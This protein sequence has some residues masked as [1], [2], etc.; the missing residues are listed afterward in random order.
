MGIFSRVLCKTMAIL[1]TI[2]V[3]TG[4]ATVESDRF[5]P[6]VFA[7]TKND[8]HIRPTHDIE[9][10]P[11]PEEIIDSYVY[12]VCRSYSNVNPNLVR[13]II[14]QESR[15][16]PEVVNYD[17][18]CVGLMQVSIFWHKDRA[19]S[20]GVTDWFDPM[21]NIRIGVDYISELLD[22]YEDPKL[23]VMVYNLGDSKAK[24]LY[25]KGEISNYA[26]SVFD[27]MEALESGGD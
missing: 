12:E 23:V 15:Y 18:T 17:G 21:S 20:L 9:P 6:L 1:V 11:T 27:R 24:S 22:R 2:F 26:R 7:E 19:A 8:W 25:A 13:A 3:C 4:F 14:Y 10:M 16:Q 5:V